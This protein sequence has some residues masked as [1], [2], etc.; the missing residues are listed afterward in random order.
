MVKKDLAKILRNE[1]CCLGEN[2][3][4]VSAKSAVDG[5]LNAI[6]QELIHGGKI[7]MRGLGTFYTKPTAARVGR[8][9]KT[10]ETVNIPAGRALR[11]R[12]SKGLR[13]ALKIR[14]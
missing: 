1:M 5:L 10:G 13:E 12:F 11:F 14:G 4:W 2:V 7:T 3:T 6:E 9:P 8:N